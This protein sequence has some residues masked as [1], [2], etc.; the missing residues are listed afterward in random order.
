MAPVGEWGHDTMLSLD[1]LALRQACCQR[2][3]ALCLTSGPESLPQ[4]LPTP[5]LLEFKMGQYTTIP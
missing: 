3:L 5:P 1:L 4:S 2:W